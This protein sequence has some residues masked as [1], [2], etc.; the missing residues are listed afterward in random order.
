MLDMDDLLKSNGVR[1]PVDPELLA[2]LQAAYQEIDVISTAINAL[3]T[4]TNRKLNDALAELQRRDQTVIV[5]TQ[6]YEKEMEKRIE[7]EKELVIC[8]RSLAMTIKLLEG[9]DK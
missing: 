3:L 2:D 1:P 4:D 6:R 8:K 5:W 7:V 9:G